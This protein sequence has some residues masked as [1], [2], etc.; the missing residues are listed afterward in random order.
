MARQ[1]LSDNLSIYNCLYYGLIPGLIWQ[2]EL[3]EIFTVEELNSTIGR[4]LN[5]KY[6]TDNAVHLMLSS[7]LSGDITMLPPPLLQLMDTTIDETIKWIPIHMREILM[8]YSKYDG[9][10]N[11][12]RCHL[13]YL[14]Q[15]LDMVFNANYFGQSWKN[16]FAIVLGIRCIVCKTF[17]PMLLHDC[18]YNY[19]SYNLISNGLSLDEFM[20]IDDLIENMRLPAT[21]PHIVIYEPSHAQ[22]E[23][24][25]FIIA[26]YQS[27]NSQMLYGWQF[28]QGNAKPSQQPSGKFNKFCDPR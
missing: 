19:T 12:M 21:F 1:N 7:F 16:L 10:S 18:S 2:R 15:K 20:N 27:E 26:I 11:F 8:S 14:V 13:K 25:D 4:C 3:S 17:H 28:Q 23:L 24:Y 5:A 22:F 6:G 9:I